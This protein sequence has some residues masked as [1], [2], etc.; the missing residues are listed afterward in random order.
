LDSGSSLVARFVKHGDQLSR[1]VVEQM[2]ELK[3]VEGEKMPAPSFRFHR[4]PAQLDQ[5]VDRVV[6]R[7]P[8]A[9]S[10]PALEGRYS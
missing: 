7:F 6:G 4:P 2:V 8:V 3:A 9:R 1:Q 5:P 10:E